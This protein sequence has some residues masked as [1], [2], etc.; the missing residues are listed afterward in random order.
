MHQAV[1]RL[2]GFVKE[3]QPPDTFV[4]WGYGLNH[5]AIG[6]FVK[7]PT[8]QCTGKEMLDEVLGHLTFDAHR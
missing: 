6:D 2:D 1:E 5:D 3:Y 8:A 7:I 4:W